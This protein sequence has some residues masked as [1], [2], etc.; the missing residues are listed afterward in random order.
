M[1][2]I[3]SVL[4]EPHYA[5]VVHLWAEMKQRFDVGNPEATAVPHFSY[6]VATAYDLDVCN[7]VLLETAVSTPPF[8]V[9]A[10]G[11]GIFSGEVPVV[12]IPIA[13]SPSL[14]ALHNL[15]TSRLEPITTSSL[16]YYAPV[17]WFPHITLANG[18]MSPKQLGEIVVWLNTLPLAWE[19]QVTNL[20]LLHDDSS[21]LTALNKVFLQAQV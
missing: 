10:T 11:I 21:Q 3:V 8:T 14:M 4:G 12:Y 9:K 18:N 20:T 6:H 7:Q 15:L 17:N 16:E 19:V 1:H 5:Q 2:G 13:R